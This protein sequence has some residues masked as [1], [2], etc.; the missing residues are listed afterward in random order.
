[1]MQL[2]DDTYGFFYYKIRKT[3]IVGEYK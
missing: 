3:Y 2:F 1:M